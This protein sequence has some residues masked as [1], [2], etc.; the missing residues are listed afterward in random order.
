MVGRSRAG[1]WIYGLG[2]GCQ[3]F[4]RTFQRA[5]WIKGEKNVKKNSKEQE[6]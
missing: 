5:S 3:Q 4:K 1:E 6:R 2:K